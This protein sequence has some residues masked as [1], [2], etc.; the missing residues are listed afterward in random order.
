MARLSATIIGGGIFGLWQAF[1]LARR[2][3]DVTLIE[4]MTEAETGGA[5]RFADAARW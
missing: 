1:E 4:A 3:H 2:D 5:S